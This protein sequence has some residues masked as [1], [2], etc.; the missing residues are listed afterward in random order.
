MNIA[1]IVLNIPTYLSMVLLILFF[2]GL[3]IAITYV[4]RRYLIGKNVHSTNNE[5]TGYIFSV[6]AGFYALLLSFIVFQALGNY[7][8]VMEDVDIEG[9]TAKSIYRQ[10]RH[11]PDSAEV[12]L[13]KNEFL[14]Y[15]NLVITEEYPNMEFD[16][17]SKSTITSFERV[18]EMIENLNHSKD[19]IHVKAPTL[20][21]SIIDLS[22]YRS[23]RVLANEAE[24]PWVM[25]VVL[26]I[27][28]LMITILA[29]FLH[30]GRPRFQLVLNGFM[31]AFIG[32]IFFLIILLD[33]PFKGSL[34][35]DP[36]AYKTILELNKNND[37][38]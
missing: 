16:I 12:I 25:W 26:L 30:A 22:K 29:A 9:S 32:L 37:L 31:G 4:T 7:N 35:V 36:T 15:V 11:Y 21:Q 38:K 10:L 1:R 19:D 24:I 13:L 34:K 8:N 14:N 2:A 28:G 33:H 18:F 20:F 23:L 27:G 3:S 17:Q 6:V 5:I